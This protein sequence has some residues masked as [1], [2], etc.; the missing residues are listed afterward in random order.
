MSAPMSLDEVQSVQRML[1]SAGCYTG[2]INGVWTAAVDDAVRGQFRTQEVVKTDPLS[3]GQ[4]RQQP[5]HALK[6]VQPDAEA[7][8]KILERAAAGQGLVGKR[9]HHRD[10]VPGSMLKL[11]H[12]HPQALR[13]CHGRAWKDFRTGRKFALT[14]RDDFLLA[15]HPTLH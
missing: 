10:Q 14:G 3:P 13:R 5:L 7:F 6:H 15:V 4:T 1:A 8:L 11:C 9:A 2:L 12:E